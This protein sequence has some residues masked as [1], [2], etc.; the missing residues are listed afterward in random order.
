MRYT[1]ICLVSETVDEKIGFNEEPILVQSPLLMIEYVNKVNFPSNSPSLDEGQTGLLVF[2]TL[3]D[4]NHLRSGIVQDM[5]F[6]FHFTV[7]LCIMHCIRSS[8]DCPDIPDQNSLI[9]TTTRAPPF[10][11]E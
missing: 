7:I 6:S 11:T 5:L 9:P 4:G 10:V 2:H 1:S 3:I 8:H